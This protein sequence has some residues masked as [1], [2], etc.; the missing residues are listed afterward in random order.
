MSTGNRLNRGNRKE[1]AL[2]RLISAYPSHGFI[3][4]RDEA[5]SLFEH[6]RDVNPLEESLWAAAGSTLSKLREGGVFLILDEAAR[7]NPMDGT[8]KT[9][10]QEVWRV[11]RA[12]NRAA[13]QLL[14]Q[15]AQQQRRDLA[16]LREAAQGSQKSESHRSLFR[17]SAHSR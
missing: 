5:V 15:M 6:V 14:G 12:R 2:A 9:D 16:A 4:D 17:D 11:R 13:S 1:G 8:V 3:I 7:A 10:L